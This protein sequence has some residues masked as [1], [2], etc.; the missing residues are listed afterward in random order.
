MAVKFTVLDLNYILT[1]IK[2]AEAGQPPVNP[3]LSFGL[4]TVSG[5]GNNLVPGQTNFGSTDQ[6]FPTITDPLFQK[7]QGNTS[8][9][10]T[11]GLV[12]DAQPRMISNLIS[13]QTTA[14]P[15]AIAAQQQELSFLGAGYQNTTQAGT[16]KLFGTADDKP[17]TFAG[18]DGILGTADDITTFGNPATPTDAS[19]SSR[20]SRAWRRACSSTT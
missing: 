5:T 14:N 8:Y 16:D 15:A 1:Q 6:T 7:A 13:D 19:S 4:R 9:A 10:S 12:T 20:P 3:L 17:T 18:P 11:S 2:M